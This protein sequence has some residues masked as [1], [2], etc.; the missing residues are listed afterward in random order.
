MK[1]GS[2][3]AQ[4]LMCSPNDYNILFLNQAKTLDH[5]F[6]GQNVMNQELK[7]SEKSKWYMMLIFTK[8]N[9]DRLE[10]HVKQHKSQ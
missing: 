2:S 8:Y 1:Y 5:G 10:H 7:D 3:S 6:E 9:H 4:S